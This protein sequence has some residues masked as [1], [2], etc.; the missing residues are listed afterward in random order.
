MDE[1]ERPQEC[2][3]DDDDVETRLFPSGFFDLFGESDESR[4]REKNE[5]IGGNNP[6]PP[7][8]I[9]P[10]PPT[11]PSDESI[12]QQWWGGLPRDRK[13]ELGL[14]GAIVFLALVQLTVLISN[15]NST[16]QQAN[17]LIEAARYSA[18]A[19][20]RNAQAAQNFAGSAESINKGIRNAVDRLNA[21]AQ[22][23]SD[24][25]SAAGDQSRASISSSITAQKQLETIQHQ[26]ETSQ[27]AW[28]GISAEISRIDW[29]SQPGGSAKL[30]FGYK[31]TA[32]NFG[33]LPASWV[34]VL[35]DENPIGVPPKGEDSFKWVMKKEEDFCVSS[36]AK[37]NFPRQT[38]HGAITVFPHQRYTFDE[39]IGLDESTSIQTWQKKELELYFRGCVIYQTPTSEGFRQT[40]FLYAP[41]RNAPAF[42][43]PKYLDTIKDVHLVDYSGET[44]SN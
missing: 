8:P 31:I 2:S 12:Y 22:A 3:D 5:G 27:R 29:I 21:Q 38:G 25:A 35:Y 19:A 6:P 9:P 39:R 33:N 23:T 41:M 24:V 42:Q 36:I 10:V 20:D 7:P 14:T 28:L 32:E 26:F 17:R 44:K 16:T 30:I 40:G 11:G 18:Y 4:K 15:N 37:G 13:I 1:Q 43:F 34:Y